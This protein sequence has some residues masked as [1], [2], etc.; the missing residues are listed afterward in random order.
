MSVIDISVIICTRNRAAYLQKCLDSLLVQSL[1]PGRYEVIVVDNGSEDST[2]DD[3]R[4]RSEAT[5]SPAI[6]YLSETRLGLSVAR[7]TG[8]QAASGPLVAFL[9]DDAFAC[10]EW[11][12]NILLAFAAGGQEL[13]CVGG[14]IELVWEKARPPWLS[15][16]LLG[17][18]GKLDIAPVP[19]QLS[20]N[21]YLYGGNLAVR[22][23]LLQ[24]VG[25][26]DPSLGRRGK[27]LI[28]NEEID[29]QDRLRLKGTSRYYDPGV[30]VYHHARRECVSRRWYLQRRFWQGVSES[31]DL[32]NKRLYQR[33]MFMSSFRNAMFIFRKLLS[34]GR[35]SANFASVLELSYYLGRLYGF[36]RAG[37]R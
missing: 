12:E 24:E 4:A 14:K 18:L 25:M 21:Q 3:V 1:P 30:L 17:P 37:S 26:F 16:T 35:E 9:D 27:L 2:A 22:K 29:L 20:A 34:F 7:N 11:L 36:S 6:R 23:T 5:P 19:V 31:T 8:I 15:D 13:G 10:A 28:S 32:V 33:E